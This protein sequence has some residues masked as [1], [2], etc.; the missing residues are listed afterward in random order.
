MISDILKA[1][2]LLSVASGASMAEAARANDL[3]P[4]QVRYAIYRI[5]RSVGRSQWI[6][7]ELSDI[8]ADPKKYIDFALSIINSSK[9]ALRKALREQLTGTL[10]PRSPDELSPK[11]VSNYTAQLLMENGFSSTAISEIQEWLVHNG[12]TLKRQALTEDRYFNLAKQ[13]AFLLSAFGFNMD[14]IIT[15]LN[16]DEEPVAPDLDD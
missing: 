6:S 8:R 15:L 4:E 10:K 3:K 13:S 14:E 11:Y 12:S 9:Y 1:K 16:D 7:S 5:C 2:I